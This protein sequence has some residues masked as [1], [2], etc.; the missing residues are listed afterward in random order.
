MPYRIVERR[1]G[2]IEKKRVDPTRAN[3]VLG[4]IAKETLEDTLLSAWRWQLHLG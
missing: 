4:W 1:E 3:N 2:N